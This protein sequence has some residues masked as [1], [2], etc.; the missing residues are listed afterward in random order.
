[1]DCLTDLFADCLGVPAQELSDESSPDTV[2]QWDS[3]KAME[4]VSLLEATFE[5]RL[6]TREIMK[7]CT[8]GIAREVLQS[9]GVDV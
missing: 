3:M 6:T 1:M 9:K 4:L 2:E 8:I 5:I 7:M